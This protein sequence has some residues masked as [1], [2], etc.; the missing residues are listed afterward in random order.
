M[1]ANMKGAQKPKTP[2]QHAL[3][4]GYTH[5]T[6][7]HAAPGHSRIAPTLGVRQ[8]QAHDALEHEL[9]PLPLVG[10]QEGGEHGVHH[11]WVPAC[12]PRLPQDQGLDALWEGGFWR[13]SSRCTFTCAQYGAAQRSVAAWQWPGGSTAVAWWPW[14]RC[15]A[16]GCAHVHAHVIVIVEAT[17]MC[18][19]H[20]QL[21]VHVMSVYKPCK[22]AEERSKAQCGERRRG[23]AERGMRPLESIML[24]LVPD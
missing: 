21:C 19:V 7:L 22:C 3:K 1:F 4:H 18:S 10:P 6:T 2:K 15:C 9:H 17:C 24:C 23:G 12:R 16:S 14:W 5:A 11:H 20:V 13:L 8:S